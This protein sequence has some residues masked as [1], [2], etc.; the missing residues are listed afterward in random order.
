[1][2]LGDSW[3]SVAKV[4]QECSAMFTDIGVYEGNR[5]AAQILRIGNPKE[6]DE[7]ATILRRV[8]MLCLC[9]APLVLSAATGGDC[10]HKLYTGFDSR[11]KAKI[12]GRLGTGHESIVGFDVVR[13]TPVVSLPHRLVL[14]QKKRLN[15]FVEDEVQGIVSDSAGN[16]ILQVRDPAN[17]ERS[18]V[19]Q[20]GSHGLQPNS[21]LTQDVRGTLHGSGTTL[22]IEAI[23]DQTQTAL[24]ARR[25]DGAYTVMTNLKGELRTLSWNKNGLAAVVSNTALIWPTGS[26]EVTALAADT[27]L[28]HARDICMIG[29]DRAILALNDS[30][31][32]LTHENATV[33]VGMQARCAWDGKSLY[34]L[35][36]R[37]GLIWSVSGVEQLGTSAGDLAYAGELIGSLSPDYPNDNPVALEAARLVGCNEVMRLRPLTLDAATP[38]WETALSNLLA[39]ATQLVEEKRYDEASQAYKRVLWAD[40]GNLKAKA[41]LEKVQQA[42][43]VERAVTIEHAKQLMDDGKYDEAASAYR[44]VL[45]TDK[46]NLM[47]KSGLEQVQRAQAAEREIAVR[48]ETIKPAL[49]HARQLMDEGKYEEAAA[50]YRSVLQTSKANAEAKV[51]L[52]EVQ[53][54]KAAEREIAVRQQTVQPALEHAKQLMDQGKYDEATQAYRR[55]LQTNKANA[56]AKAGLEEV[57][58]AQ[59]A[60]REIANARTSSTPSVPTIAHAKQLMDEGK[61]DEATETYKQ[62]LRNDKNNVRAKA[63]LEKVQRAQAAERQI[64]SLR[65]SPVQPQAFAEQGREQPDEQRESQKFDGYAFCFAEKQDSDQ[66][67]W[68]L[69]LTHSFN[70]K[71]KEP[72]DANME[73]ADIS[74]C[75]VD[76]NKSFARLLRLRYEMDE[77]QQA[78]I[79]NCHLFQSFAQ[80]EGKAEELRMRAVRSNFRIDQFDWSPSASLPALPAQV[81]YGFCAAAK[82]Q[83]HVVTQ[84]FSANCRTVGCPEWDDH[85]VKFIENKYQ[86]VGGWARCFS[87][88]SEDRSQRL[89]Q[90]HL[91]EKYY[92]PTERINWEP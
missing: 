66:Q 26:K 19:K 57:Q 37:S 65:A 6:L 80:A 42:Q 61:Y 68:T 25:R 29:S 76:L 16:L 49:E 10:Q 30:V 33:L 85:W 7:N 52:E 72:V 56:Q 62:I 50:A 79:R 78:N 12:V 90:Q 81:V 55:V 75:A 24:L 22:F 63:G 39:L 82:S 83:V 51:G 84:L 71:C 13:G 91:Q 89:L 23:S 34:L 28:E 21:K 92:V 8:V 69:G 18:L 87:D 64:A 45:R 35:D 38:P 36:E 27:G 86:G 32:V 40:K 9:F 70:T 54:A 53:H 73:M 43:V 31:L 44:Q 17:S 60:E 74:D 58:R 48:Q 4:L 3:E 11:V 88:V 14:F 2:P 67:H 59:A 41:G 1:M 46:S 5:D 15:L 20:L 47:A 77:R